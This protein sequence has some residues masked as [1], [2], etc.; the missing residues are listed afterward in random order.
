MSSRAAGRMPA[1]GPVVA[2]A[3]RAVRARLEGLK[4]GV[5]V[6]EEAGE[7][8]AFGD[9]SAPEGTRAMTLTPATRTWSR[10]PGGHPDQRVSAAVRSPS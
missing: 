4:G 9:A 8:R 7:R 1:S 3:R 10:A 2:L 5:L 6:L